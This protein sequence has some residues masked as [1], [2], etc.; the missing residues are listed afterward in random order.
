MLALSH[1]KPDSKGFSIIELVFAIVILS[2]L[3]AILV[4]VLVGH[5][6]SARI[7]RDE[8]NLD[9]LCNAIEISL[10]NTTVYDYIMGYCTT[11]PAGMTLY[12]R[13]SANAD[14]GIVIQNGDNSQRTADNAVYK[15]LIN[16]FST[17]HYQS[18][19]VIF[20]YSYRMASKRY[21]Q[22]SDNSTAAAA[23]TVA[24]NAE[25]LI[26]VTRILLP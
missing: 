26:S 15:L 23:I 22:L 1:S 9:E 14:E 5:T 21:A 3:A 4:P 13:N 12:V 10:A 2:I 18:G 25:G 19:S 17:A 8:D 24:F 7:A 11:H 16:S 6:E 20:P